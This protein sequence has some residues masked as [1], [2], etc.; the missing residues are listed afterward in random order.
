MGGKLAG[1]VVC[2]LFGAI[3]VQ[4]IL[5]SKSENLGKRIEQQRKHQVIQFLTFSSPNVGGHQQPFQKVT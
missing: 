4:S 2:G 1:R 3:F 5:V